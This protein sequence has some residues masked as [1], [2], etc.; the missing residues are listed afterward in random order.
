MHELN[1]YQIQGVE[2]RLAQLARELLSIANE[3]KCSI[4]LSASNYKDL[5]LFGSVCIHTDA[6]HV[7]SRRYDGVKGFEG[8]MSEEPSFVP[9]LFK[10]EGGDNEKSA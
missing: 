4:S 7:I 5:G 2:K 1:D 3:T 6:N 10:K 8:V 9:P